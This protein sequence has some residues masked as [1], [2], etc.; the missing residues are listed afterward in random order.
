MCVIVFHNMFHCFWK[1]V[2]ICFKICVIVF[3]IMCFVVF[4]NVYHLVFI[5]CVIVFHNVYNCFFNVFH[6]VLQSHRRQ[7][8][9]LLHVMCSGHL[10]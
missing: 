6:C 4:Y 2:T 1:F 9:L 5:M 3:F 8:V 10:W 7:L